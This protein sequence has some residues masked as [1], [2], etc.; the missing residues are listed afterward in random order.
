MASNKVI[1]KTLYTNRQYHQPLSGEGFGAIYDTSWSTI[2]NS[3]LFSNYI[4]GVNLGNF[5]VQ[6]NDGQNNNALVHSNGNWIPPKSGYGC[7]ITITS[8]NPTGGITGYRINEGGV[9]YKEGDRFS[10]IVLGAVNGLV[11]V[12]G[13]NNGVVTNNGLKIINAGKGYGISTTNLIELNDLYWTHQELVAFNAD[14]SIGDIEE[15]PNIVEQDWKLKLDTKNLTSFALYGNLVELIKANFIGIVNTFPA[16]LFL[17]KKSYV[18]NNITEYYYEVN[19]PF[20]INIFTS[21]E[22]PHIDDIRVFQQNHNKYEVIETISQ[23]QTIVNCVEQ[24]GGIRLTECKRDIQRVDT[25]YRYVYIKRTGFVGYVGRTNVFDDG[26]LHEEYEPSNGIFTLDN[27]SLIVTTDEDFD[28]EELEEIFKKDYHP[29]MRLLDTITIRVLSTLNTPVVPNTCRL[30]TNADFFTITISFNYDDEHNPCELINYVADITGIQN[31]AEGILGFHIKPKEKYVTEFFNNLSDFQTV[32][33]NRNTVPK[34]TSTFY[35]PSKDNDGTYTGMYANESFT[36]D[37]EDGWNID[38]KSVSYQRMINTLL[39]SAEYMDTM[40]CDNI[41]RMLTHDSIKNL[42][43]S[44]N[45]IE[46]EALAQAHIVGGTYLNK[47]LRLYGRSYDELKKYIHGIEVINNLT[48]NQLDNYPD[49]LLKN[50]VDIAGWKPISVVNFDNIDIQT[51][52]LYGGWQQK[53]NA[54]DIENEFYRRLLLNS[55]HIASWKGTKHGVEMLMNLFGVDRKKWGL[56]EVVYV[57]TGSRYGTSGPESDNMIPDEVLAPTGSIRPGYIYDVYAR[58]ATNADYVEY[59]GVNYQSGQEFVGVSGVN[60]NTY[61]PR[62]AAQV[63]FYPVKNI[64]SLNIK[65]PYTENG[66]DYNISDKEQGDQE[67]QHILPMTKYFKGDMSVICKKCDGK[68][69]IVTDRAVCFQC[70]GI[71]Y[72]RRYDAVPFFH[73]NTE[74]LYYQQF[75]G[76]YQDTQAELRLVETIEDLKNLIIRLGN[77]EGTLVFVRNDD[78]WKPTANKSNFSNYWVLVDAHNA[79]NKEGWAN[80]THADTEGLYTITGETSGVSVTINVQAYFQITTTNE[81]NNPHTGGTLG[82]DYGNSYLQ[83]IGY[84]I[85]D[86]NGDSITPQ[87]NEGNKKGDVRNLNGLFNYTLSNSPECIWNN[88]QYYQLENVGF[89][90]VGNIDNKGCWPVYR[91]EGYGRKI[92]T[93]FVPTKNVYE[94]AVDMVVIDNVSTKHWEDK[95]MINKEYSIYRTYIDDVRFRECKPILREDRTA[96]TR[97]IDDRLAS[98]IDFYRIVNCKNITFRYDSIDGS[99][100][101]FFI[102]NI[103]PYLENLI[104]TNTIIDIDFGKP[105]M[106][107]IG[108]MQI[109]AGTGDQCDEEP[110]DKTAI[111]RVARVRNVPNIN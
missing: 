28:S 15:I 2:Q 9:G 47:I 22:D 51:D 36:L 1:Q 70:N 52:Q 90:L 61:V 95:L 13:V 107:G 17:E 60:N 23:P 48:Y 74:R 35:T 59:N 108:V 83:H 78:E 92:D 18:V 43:W 76:W 75:G 101:Y 19:N 72:V 88:P 73:G 91:N 25:D 97:H 24:S 104:P 65:T 16:S 103:M 62:G 38:L 45:R 27:N 26:F 56:N 33:L 94:T 31:N 81:G 105:I 37:T 86:V 55:S 85:N 80:L 29:P 42:D 46:D 21:K 99:E 10:I 102:N 58:N 41:Y 11:E 40:K 110:G 87:L 82:Y 96:N 12:I 64:I 68:G 111:N 39:E 109:S 5:K 106:C 20:N 71:G 66:E 44:L 3:P 8:V 84:R 6:F 79:M 50:E 4:D 67:E 93:G 34:Y 63:Y 14:G 89:R 53:Y 30:R 100:E 54:T 69:Y 32:I 77:E 98:A 57:A 49:A 7:F